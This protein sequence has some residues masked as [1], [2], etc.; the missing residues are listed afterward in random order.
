VSCSFLIRP[1]SGKIERKH[2]GKLFLG[3]GKR[4]G[5]RNG[6]SAKQQKKRGKKRE[7][8]RSLFLMGKKKKKFFQGGGRLAKE[9]L[10]RISSTPSR[11]R[12]HPSDLIRTEQ[13]SLKLSIGFGR[14]GEEDTP[15]IRGIGDRGV[16]IREIMKRKD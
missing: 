6:K 14:H 1:Q 3:G 10:L 8:H 15:T 9:V 13:V 5:I 4:N 2:R 7:R 12:C 16:R 11:F